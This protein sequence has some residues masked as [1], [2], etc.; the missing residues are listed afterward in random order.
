M[1]K[2]ASRT[3]VVTMNGAMG[4]G[5]AAIIVS[6]ALEYRRHYF[7]DIPQLVSGILGGLVSVTA[8]AAVIEPWEALLIGFIGGFIALGSKLIFRLRKN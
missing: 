3:A 5:F 8:P 1:W 4:G 7:L 6:A 2:I